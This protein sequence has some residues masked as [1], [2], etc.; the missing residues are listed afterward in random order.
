MSEPQ[1]INI[2][3]VDDDDIVASNKM[4]DYTHIALIGSILFHTNLIPNDLYNGYLGLVF[5]VGIIIVMMDLFDIFIR[6]SY[7]FNQY[8]YEFIYTPPNT[9]R[10]SVV[11]NYNTI[12]LS[13]L[14]T[15]CK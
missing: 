4:L 6:S 9:N 11:T 2:N 12:Q 7:D 5:G 8:D 3:N 13:N 10:S 14:P 1:I 15:I